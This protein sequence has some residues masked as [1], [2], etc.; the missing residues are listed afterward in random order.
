MPDEAIRGDAATFDHCLGP[1]PFGL[2]AQ[3]VEDTVAGVDRPLYRRQIEQLLSRGYL[4]SLE[5]A[6]AAYTMLQIYRIR[7]TM[8]EARSENQPV[9]KQTM[10]AFQDY[11]A[12]LRSQIAG[13]EKR[14]AA[15]SEADPNRELLQ[16]EEYI[17]THLGEFEHR[18]P[19]PRCGQLLTVP[20]LPHWAFAPIYPNGSAQPE[21]MVWSPELW[22]LVCDR[23][24]SLWVM[25]YVLRTS[26]EGLRTTAERRG[27]AWP[28]FIDLITEEQALGIRLRAIDRQALSQATAL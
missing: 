1:N 16:A 19:A 9:I 21:W 6:E 11:Q 23:T 2:E 17:Q 22:A 20:A 15:I 8:E 28:P 3:A 13:L 25:A 18:C 14:Q 4:P 27:E 10:D 12:T 24:I 26:P 7:L 5:L